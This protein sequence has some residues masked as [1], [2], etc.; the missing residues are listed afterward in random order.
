MTRQASQTDARGAR[1]FA[2]PATWFVMA[3]DKDRPII[4]GKATLFTGADPAPTSE[5]PGPAMH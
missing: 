2:K 3:A 5:T 1:L 4:I